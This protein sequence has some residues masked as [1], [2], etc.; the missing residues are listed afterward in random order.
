[1]RGN[2]CKQERR[3]SRQQEKKG[4]HFLIDRGIVERIIDYAELSPKDRV[5]EIG[6]GT[7]NLTGALA[8]HAGTVYAIEVDPDLVAGL[9]KLQDRFQNI[10]LIKGDALEVELP[11]YNK[12]VS[13]LP[14]QISSKITYR[15]LSRP[16]DTAVLMYQ[17]EFARRMTAGPGQ[18]EY[19]RLGMVAG[20]LCRAEILEIVSRS[21]FS[22]MPEV[23]SAIVWLRPR[24]HEADAQ[25][26][27]R[28]VERLFISRRKKVKKA[29]ASV[30]V[31]KERLAMIDSSMLEKRPEELTPK[32]AAEL[33]LEIEF[34]F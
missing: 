26:F 9:Q 20:Y 19:G 10:S 13:N 34:K 25:T 32:E 11:D 22:P 17:K 12:V 8:T 7:G 2:G 3:I 4:Q 21:A 14:Y 29:L 33:A 16:F 5:L 15:L 31:P 30:G 1:M 18:K 6:P 24:E 27:M 23:E 28:F